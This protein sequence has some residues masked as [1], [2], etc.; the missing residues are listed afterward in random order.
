MGFYFQISGV[1]ES[2]R[3]TYWDSTSRRF[4]E[5]LLPLSSHPRGLTIEFQDQPRYRF[6]FRVIKVQ[7]RAHL[8]Q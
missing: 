6:T 5:S 4:Y 1:N 2:R 8:I 7:K 3:C